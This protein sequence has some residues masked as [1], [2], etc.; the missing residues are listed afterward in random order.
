MKNLETYVNFVRGLKQAKETIAECEEQ[1][2]RLEQMKVLLQ[3][4]RDKDQQGSSLQSPMSLV[5]RLQGY[6]L[7]QAAHGW[8]QR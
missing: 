5:Q 4:N 3:K 8:F 2:V 1:K 6:W 7:L